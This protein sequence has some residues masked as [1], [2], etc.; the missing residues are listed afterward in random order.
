MERGTTIGWVNCRLRRIGKC[1][2]PQG[3]SAEKMSRAD[4]EK[5]AL[6]QSARVKP[7]LLTTGKPAES[8]AEPGQHPLSDERHD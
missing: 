5:Y 7:R 3:V 1:P 8:P 4:L 6:E 2:L